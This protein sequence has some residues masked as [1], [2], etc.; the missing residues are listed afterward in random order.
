MSSADIL[1]ATLNARYSHASMGL[2]CLLANMGGLAERTAIREFT[3]H[4]APALVAERLLEERP[5]LVGFGVY[6]WNRTETEQVVRV[7]RAIA[8]EVRVVLGG[9]EISHAPQDDALA[10]LAD[11]VLAG[12]ADLEL[13][14]VVGC[15]LAGESVAR[16]ISCPAPDLALVELPY[17]HY[18]A[19]DLAHRIVYVEASRGC[20]FTCEFCLSS[21]DDGVRSFALERFLAAME[22]LLARGCTTF[23]FV[24]RTF[25]L[26]VRTSAAILAF[27][28]E[29]LRPGLFL[30]FE[31]VPDR[32]PA[33]LRDLIARFPRGVLQFEVGIQSFT[34][35]VGELIA[36]RMDR[37]RTAENLTWLH[38]ESGVHVH[39]DLIV[40]LPGE[41]LATF[42]DSYDALWW[43]RPAEIQV[44]ILKLLPG[45]PLARH[46]ATHGMVFNPRPPYDLL[47]AHAFPFALMQRLKRFARY[48]ELVVNSGRFARAVE[49]LIAR[50]GG[51][52]FHALL[53]LSDWLWARTGQDHAIALGRLY[54]LLRERLLA[55]GEE[56]AAL[57][58]DLAADLLDARGNP[59]GSLKGLPEVLRGP[60][61]RR[62]RAER[63]PQAREN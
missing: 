38:R 40:G 29:R 7:M 21:L 9:P 48:H 2:R 61:E 17:A 57:D 28:L 4:D 59:Q 46:Q 52:P 49:R 45:T 47:A 37:A 36:R 26:S 6:I 25:N 39:A 27:F 44:G 19:E 23:K 32:L 56:P 60:V 33:A 62:Q 12:E 20:P 42:A 55:L 10:G 41:T 5:R 35:A 43:L 54:E 63:A 15:L 50:G 3:I 51:R 11:A 24:D 22:S 58:E 8:P 16:R 30:H 34:P 13:P 14:R 1:L 53:E 18:S 31:M